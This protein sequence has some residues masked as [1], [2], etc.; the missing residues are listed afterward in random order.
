MEKLILLGL[1]FWINFA[2]LDG[3]PPNFS[4]RH[5]IYKNLKAD[6]SVRKTNKPEWNNPK[7]EVKMMDP[8]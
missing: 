6:K 1:A 7:P 5:I 4:E 8:R 2:M 3:F